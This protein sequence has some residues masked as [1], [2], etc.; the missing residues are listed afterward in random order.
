MKKLVLLAVLFLVA[1][2]G[3]S[4]EWPG[5]SDEMNPNSTINRM[6]DLTVEQYTGRHWN[7]LGALEKKNIVE[8]FLSGFS[9]WRDYIFD[10]DPEVYERYQHY[11][12]FLRREGVVDKII[13][14]LDRYYAINEDTYKYN[15]R[16]T[17]MIIVFYGKYWWQ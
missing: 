2:V 10:V 16:V 9:V 17:N 4:Q 5:I 8:G 13:A 1:A 14:D 11:D 15:D 6:R 12:E 7:V 3:F